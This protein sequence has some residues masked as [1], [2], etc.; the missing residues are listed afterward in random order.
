MV[1]GSIEQQVKN[2]RIYEISVNDVFTH[3]LRVNL[4][5]TTYGNHGKKK[6]KKQ[7]EDLVFLFVTLNYI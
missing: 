6:Y 5:L 7:Y 3:Y 1:Q 2:A 4:S